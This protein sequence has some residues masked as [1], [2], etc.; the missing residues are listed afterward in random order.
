MSARPPRVAQALEHRDDRVE[1]GDAAGAAAEPSARG[2]HRR[3]VAVTSKRLTS[4][5]PDPSP[6]AWPTIR[7]WCANGALISIAS[8]SDAAQPASDSASSAAARAS[9]AVCSSAAGS[10]TRPCAGPWRRSARRCVR[11]GARSRRGRA[12]SRRRSRSAARGRARGA[13]RRSARSRARPAALTG[14]K[15]CRSRAGRGDDARRVLGLEQPLR[16]EKLRPGRRRRRCRP[17]RARAGNRD[18]T[19]PARSCA[20]V[21]LGLLGVRERPGSGAGPRPRS[22][23]AR[24]R[25]PARVGRDLRLG[26]EGRR[27]TTSLT[28]MLEIVRPSQKS[29]LAVTAPSISGSDAPASFS[30]GSTASQASSLMLTSSRCAAVRAS[31]QPTIQVSLAAPSSAAKSTKRLVGESTDCLVA[32]ASRAAERRLSPAIMHDSLRH[33][34]ISLA[35]AV[36]R[37]RTLRC[38]ILGSGA[39]GLSAAPWPRRPRRARDAARGRSEGRRHHS[40]LR[41]RRVDSRLPGRR[42]RRGAA[43]ALPRRDRPRRPRPR[44][45]ARFR[46]R[47]RRRRARARGRGRAPLAAAR[48]P[49]LPCRAARRA[50]P[51]RPL[52]RAAAA[53]RRRRSSPGAC[54]TRPTSSCR[55]PTTSWRPGSSTRAS[56]FSASAT[57]Y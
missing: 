49:R 52:A 42:Q 7:C 12:P 3:P 10:S 48:L 30:A 51:G 36:P 2:V 38:R 55:S 23:R 41:R 54:A 24:N 13:G 6:S 32:C 20:I 8:S 57:G 47:R 37:E 27:T 9:G 4:A 31:P 56:P 50:P 17:G 34:V 39:A 53:G 40:A 15:D 19:R 46:A 14:S 44:R 33:R 28:F 25:G 43:L 35:Q 11:A 26:A 16:V 45:C 22:A 18:R 29:W 21:A 1:A 5:S